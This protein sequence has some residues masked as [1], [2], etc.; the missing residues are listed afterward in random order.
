VGACDTSAEAA[1]AH[2]E[3]FERMGP[4]RRALAAMEMSDDLRAVALDALSARHPDL[5]HREL[6]R[7]LVLELHG[8]DLPP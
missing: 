2:T 7:L 6:I 1:A 4:A 8:V 5:G 3:V